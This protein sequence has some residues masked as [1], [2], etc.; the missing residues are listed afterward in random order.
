MP[1]P[2]PWRFDWDALWTPVGQS[3]AAVKRSQWPWAVRAT[4][5][6]LV[7]KKGHATRVEDAVS[8]SFL[9]PQKSEEREV[10]TPPADAIECTENGTSY[11]LCP[12]EALVAVEASL[13]H[14][15]QPFG[16]KI[17]VANPDGESWLRGFELPNTGFTFLGHKAVTEH[18]RPKPRVWAR[19][20]WFG[21]D[22]A[23]RPP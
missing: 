8:L 15:G 11:L 17:V 20:R 6:A 18:N 13:R 9:L 10:R 22:Q 2:C 14:A 7:A 5:G 19:K 1:H 21:S 3:V 16:G 4:D 23:L 12:P